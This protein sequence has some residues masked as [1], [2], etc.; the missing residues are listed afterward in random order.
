M[1]DKSDTSDITAEKVPPT[2]EP[3]NKGR[4]TCPK[5]QKEINRK[6]MLERYA[7]GSLDNSGANNG[8][9]KTWK[10]VFKNGRELIVCGLQPW[11][12]KN[13][14]S[15]SGIKKIAYGETN[16]YRDIVSVDLVAHEGS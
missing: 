14:Y 10:I 8:R 15:R 1:F 5:H 13:G 6:M 16:K 4:H 2:R 9:A 7:N 11:A 3:W 12:V